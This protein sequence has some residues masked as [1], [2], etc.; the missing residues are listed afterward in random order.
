ME[1]YAHDRTHGKCICCPLSICLQD[2]ELVWFFDTAEQTTLA[3]ALSATNV[4]VGVWTG[5]SQDTTGRFAWRAPSVCF[6]PVTDSAAS[7]A[8][9][10][11]RA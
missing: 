7:G 6:W 9:A 8:S 5:L 1:A 3:N 2:M 4:S 11:C 10:G